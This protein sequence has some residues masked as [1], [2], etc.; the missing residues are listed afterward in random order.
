MIVDSSALMAILRQEPDAHA[1]SQALETAD[2]VSISAAT[3]VEACLVADSADDPRFGRALDQLIRSVPVE[4][5]SFTA[6][7]A[8][9]ARE[10][11]RVFGRGSKSKAKLNFG[12]C[13]SY[14]LAYAK[15]EPLL[16]KGEDFKHTDIAAAI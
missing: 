1:V 14:A 6:E 16:F 4:I 7:H 3:L 15:D 13:F 9:I 8:A 10:A 12:D 2:S 5:E 11:H